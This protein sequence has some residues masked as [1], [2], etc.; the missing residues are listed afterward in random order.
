MY[1]AEQQTIEECTRKR[2]FK[3]KDGSLHNTEWQAFQHDYKTPHNKDIYN[4]RLL[5]HVVLDTPDGD[6]LYLF[7]I[8]NIEEFYI[9]LANFTARYMYYS[10]DMLAYNRNKY[11]DRFTEYIVEYNDTSDY[12]VIEVY[13]MENFVA[14]YQDI[15]YDYQR[16]IDEVE[17]N[18]NIGEY[19]E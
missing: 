11:D 3:A 9:M 12:T 13:I 2:M 19:N 5:K 16:V 6:T 10:Y 14:N 7:H 1:K 15:I 8:A 4:A 17:Q 18:M